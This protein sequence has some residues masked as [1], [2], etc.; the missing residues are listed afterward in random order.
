[1]PKLDVV[2][3]SP[4]QRIEAI[5]VSG[6]RG[7][8]GPPG[9]GGTANIT[10]QYPIFYDAGSGVVG[11]VSGYYSTVSELTGASGALAAQ[12]SASS[13]GVSALNGQSGLITIQGAGSVSVFTNG[14]VITISG[15]SPTGSSSYS[16]AFS[17]VSAVP[18]GADRYYVNYPISFA[19]A[20]IVGLTLQ[21]EIDP[22]V[23]SAAVSGRATTGFWALFSDVVIHSGLSLN[24]L[25]QEVSPLSFAVVVPTGSD[26][27]YVSYPSTLSAVPVV[28][29]TLE[30]DQA[31]ST[32][33]VAVSGRSVAGFYALFTETILQTGISLNVLAR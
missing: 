11:I 10:G 29:L 12:I 2:F 27:Y 31:L 33:G 22:V 8:A 9:S 13:A 24:V 21:T 28:N 19:T 3:A 17:F 15:A 18:T 26:T 4:T 7:P 20:P 30:V 5:V 32:Y 25:A 23:Y 16:S 14:Q 1:M 6:P